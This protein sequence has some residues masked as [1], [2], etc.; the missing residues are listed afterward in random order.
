MIVYIAAPYSAPSALGVDDNLQAAITA[1]LYVAL[2]G[3]TPLVPHLSH[4]IDQKAQALGMPIG[5]EEW[6]RHCLA[7]LDR[8][9]ALLYLGPSP[10]ADRELA[11]AEERGLLIFPSLD[12]FSRFWDTRP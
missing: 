8:C 1:G 6:M 11:R 2:R 4:Y 3:H 9:D 10:G 12:V 7:L 5:Y